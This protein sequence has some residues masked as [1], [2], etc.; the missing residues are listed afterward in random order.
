MGIQLASQAKTSS[1]PITAKGAKTTVNIGENERLTSRLC[2]NA[3]VAFAIIPKGFL[4]LC[5]FYLGL[6]GLSRLGA[7]VSA[8][9]YVCRGVS[10]GSYG[11]G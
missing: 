3:V 9:V 8:R 6:V 1:K 2:V 7:C 4:R 11:C 5:P 10:L